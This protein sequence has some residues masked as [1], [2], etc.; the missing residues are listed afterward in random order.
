MHS[1][2]W[3]FQQELGSAEKLALLYLCSQ[4]GGCGLGTIDR[5]RLT[6]ALG[7]KARSVQRIVK[8]LKDEGLLAEQGDFYVV[9]SAGGVVES[10]GIL[11]DAAGHAPIG[12][13]GLDARNDEA[14]ARQVAAAVAEKLTVFETRVIAT[15]DDANALGTTIADAINDTLNNFEARM[16]ERIDRMA[17]FHVE[18][19]SGPTPPPDPVT[20]NPLYGTLIEA[21]VDK[22]RAYV[23]SEQDLG[24]DYNYDE[25]T[26]AGDE[27]PDSPTG[28]YE[29][30]L[31]IL[32]GRDA[33]IAKETLTR[34]GEIESA[35]NKHT[36]KGEHDAFVDLY[37][38]IVQSARD[39]AGR[40]SIDDFCNV[41]NYKAHRAPWDAPAP[42]T[43]TEPEI[44]AEIATMLSEIAAANSPLCTVQPRTEERGEDGVK[45]FEPLLAYH[46]RVKAKYE[47]MLMQK[48]MG[49]V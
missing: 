33:L 30:V 24:N 17:L 22:D 46:H 47:Q 40:L 45:H 20:E 3:A 1:L 8:N 34:W 37:P 21:G 27:Y 15:G 11:N 42:A 49:I 35:E 6:E 5:P 38:A 36:T 39:N 25:A 18:P 12:R 9:G 4:A 19:D 31:R 29:R 43:A 41:E 16:G 2:E 26:P 14:L 48:Q 23:L 28:R 44:E 7:V 32:D 10:G 13:R